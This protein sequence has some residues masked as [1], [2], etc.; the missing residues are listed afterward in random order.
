MKV[1]PQRAVTID[2]G[3]WA[4]PG[5]PRV[6]I[7]MPDPDDALEWAGAIRRRGC[8]VGICRGPDS[9]AD[10]AA[11]CPLHRLE[12][13]V[14]V[15]GADLVVTALDLESDAGREVLRGLR[16]RYPAVPLVV[17]ATVAQAIGLEDVLAGCVV[18]PVDADP[19]RVA[20]VVA[21]TLTVPNRGVE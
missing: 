11:R 19:E 17:A 8:T 12:P 14:A 5:R 6:L 20:A 10:P 1:V 4:H 2:L 7:E 21:E 16:T 15:E 18:V 3:P 13:C 9:A